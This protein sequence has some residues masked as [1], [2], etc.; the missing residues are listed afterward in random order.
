MDDDNDDDDA[1]WFDLIFFVLV[2]SLTIKLYLLEHTY[3]YINIEIKS[4]LKSWLLFSHCFIFRNVCNMHERTG[5][6]NQ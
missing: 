3:I 4:L 1:V 6:K 5:G 2:V